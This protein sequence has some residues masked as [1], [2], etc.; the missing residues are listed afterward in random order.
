MEILPLACY[1]AIKSAKVIEFDWRNEDR[2][3]DEEGY[4]GPKQE[5]GPKEEK[6]DRVY[7]YDEESLHRSKFLKFYSALGFIHTPQRQEYDPETHH[8]SSLHRTAHVSPSS[9][10][11]TRPAARR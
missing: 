8:Q 3:K 11:L 4:Q 9:H 7:I 2:T 6:S 10:L 1:F 5:N